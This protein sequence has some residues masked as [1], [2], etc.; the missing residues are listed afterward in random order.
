LALCV[1]QHLE[2][3][4]PGCEHSVRRTI[5]ADPTEAGAPKRLCVAAGL[6][7]F[8]EDAKPSGREASRDV[9]HQGRRALAACAP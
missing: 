1:S 7:F 4:H 3:S 8:H 5:R 9:H 2:I 6:Q